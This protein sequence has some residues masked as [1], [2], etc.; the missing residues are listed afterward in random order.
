MPCSWVP[1]GC[2]MSSSVSFSSFLGWTSGSW[3]TWNN[4]GQPRRPA[5]VLAHFV[6]FCRPASFHYSEVPHNLK[7]SKANN[8]G[9][10]NH[11][12]MQKVWQKGWK[13][14]SLKFAYASLCPPTQC[15]ASRH[16]LKLFLTAGRCRMMLNESRWARGGRAK[17]TIQRWRH[18]ITPS[19]L[20]NTSLLKTGLISCDCCEW[21][22]REQWCGASSHVNNRSKLPRLRTITRMASSPQTSSLLNHITHM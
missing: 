22:L 11:H 8:H 12:G 4:L 2:S 17:T 14:A 9:S 20:V 18:R 19:F 3:P 1:S 6:R 7:Y 13:L 10:H 5:S 21:P 15:N 16:Y